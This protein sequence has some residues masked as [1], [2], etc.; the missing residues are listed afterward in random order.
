MFQIKYHS[1][2]Q[3]LSCFIAHLSHFV[4]PI[5]FCW[6]THCSLARN[7]KGGCLRL[8]EVFLLGS[9]PTVEK[10]NQAKSIVGQSVPSAPLPVSKRE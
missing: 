7:G 8:V 2:I 3:F 1:E 6:K 9:S 10:E 4:N 5:D